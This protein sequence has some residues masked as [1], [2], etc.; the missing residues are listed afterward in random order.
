MIFAGSINIVGVYSKVPRDKGHFIKQGSS[1][2]YL[3][4]EI[5]PNHEL[6]HFRFGPTGNVQVAVSAKTQEDALDEAAD[7]LAKHDSKF[8]FD[9]EALTK[10][11]GKLR[12]FMRRNG[13]GGRF[14]DLSGKDQDIVL[15][16]MAKD[17]VECHR[18][19]LKKSY[20]KTP[21]HL[22]A[23]PL[24]RKLLALSDH[25]EN[26]DEGEVDDTA[27]LEALY[28]RIKKPAAPRR[29]S[30]KPAT[31]KRKSKLKTKKRAKVKAAKPVKRRKLRGVVRRSDQT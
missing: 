26:H 7:W 14:D 18:G 24:R 9:S 8:A 25:M 10:D 27:A 3:P 29:S 30:K 12:S 16:K 31:K 6:W 13:M 17:Y 28:G 20:F 19:Y 5:Y 4:E 22:K 15:E 11:K 1:K 2:I 23:G 21:K